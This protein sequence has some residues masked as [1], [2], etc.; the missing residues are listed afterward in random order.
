MSNESLP[1]ADSAKVGS[2]PRWF[3]PQWFKQLIGGGENNKAQ[4]TRQPVEKIQI[5]V[6]HGV[7]SISGNQLKAIPLFSEC[8]ADFLDRLAGKFNSESYPAGSRIVR[9][10]DEADKFYILA[11]GEAQVSEMREGEHIELAIVGAGDFMGEIALLNNG[12]RTA[13]VDALIDCTLLSLGHRDF[14]AALGSLPRFRESL[15]ELA[16]EREFA[17]QQVEL[18]RLLA[19]L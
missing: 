11:Q 12:A 5:T 15:Q 16:N 7:A 19:I 17:N 10:G 8:D 6:Q 13:S 9:Q 4:G 14:F 18:T 3:T 1:A 2:A